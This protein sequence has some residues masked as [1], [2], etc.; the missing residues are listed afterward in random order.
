MIL[1]IFGDEIVHVGFSFSEF[2]FV[3]TFTSVPMQESL[4]SEHSSELFSDSLEHFLDGGG[5]TDEG[6]GHLETLGGDITNGGLDVVGNPFNEV[7]RVL[8]LDVEHLFVDFLGGHSTSEESRSSQVSSV[9]GISGTHH[10]LGIEHLLGQFRDGKS[11][12]LLRTSGGKGSE[13]NHEEVE[14]GERN[15]V[16]GE[17]S[18][19]GVQLTRESK[20]TS[21]TGHGSRDQVVKITV[22]GGGE[23]EGSETDI[24]KSFVIDNHTFIGVF[25]Q[26]MDGE[27]SVVG[28][29]DGIRDLG[30]GDDGE[31][32]HDSIRIFFSDLGDKESTHT[33]TSTTT[34]GVSDLETLEAITTF[35]FLSDDVQNGV[36]QFSTFSVVTLSPVV[37]STSLTENEVIRSEE[38][39]ERT[40]SD[41]IHGTGFQVHQDSSGDVS[42][43]SSFIVINVDSFQLQ[44][45]VTVIGTSGVDTVFIGNDFP[46]LGTNLVTALT[47]LDVND[48]SHF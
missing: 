3:H 16:D 21:N 9:S 40:S 24:V 18:K 11:S 42:T 8:V 33:R 1:L 41:G 2:H 44:I 19:I 29:N 37:T 45:G 15:Q 5:V 26:L 43:T 39:T 23:L 12:V 4:S 27:G 48:F 46:E 22:G 30:G 47:T 20:T 35:S 31:S 14:T 38:L 32:F 6:N 34:E 17:F 7:R 36:D 25:D 28:F 13:T 10:V